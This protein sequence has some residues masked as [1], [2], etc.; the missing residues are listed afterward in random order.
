[1]LDTLRMYGRF[2]FGLRRFLRET[3][4]LEQ[5][6]A[7]IRRRMA[8]RTDAFLRIVERGIF[9]NPSSPYLPLLRAAGCEMGDLRRMVADRGLEDTL[10]ALRGADVYVSFEEFKGRRPMV[11]GGQ[12]YHVGP[13]DF[14]NPFLRTHYETTTGGS[15]G[16][17]V[18]VPQDLD[19]LRVMAQYRLVA[20]EA[21]DILDIPKAIWRGVL[22]AGAGINTVLPPAHFGQVP[23][24]WFT[25][26][27]SRDLRPARR[28]RL[29]T[30][31]IVLISRLNGVKIPWPEPVP[32]DQAIVVARWAKD[33]VRTYGRCLV[34]TPA[35]Q[36]LRV[37]LAAR[38]QGWDLQGVVFTI[39]G[40]PITPAKARGITATGARYFTSYG[41]AES[42][43]VGMGCARPSSC[44]DVHLLKD[45]FAV[46]QHVR[47]V[48]SGIVVPAFN[49][50]SL[51]PT[52]PMILLNMESD[53]FGTLETRSCGCALEALGYT[54]H[55]GDIHS[56]GK[57]TGEGMTLVGSEMIRVL[58][59][60]LPARFGGSSLDYQLSEEEDH[61][62][63]TRLWLIVS[64]RIA[65]ADETGV[66][67]T[68]LDALA[69]S[70]VSADYARAI[71]AQAGTLRVKRAEPVWTARGKFLP[72]HVSRRGRSAAEKRPAGIA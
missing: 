37:C 33:A 21:H 29:A 14:R 63:F 9:E 8:G 31:G 46:I 24:K 58:E 39:T 13:Q 4:T 49:I 64:P 45:G 62:G 34:D 61:Q 38:E 71:W 52:A 53:D 57:L 66:I 1:M 20:R 69:A 5:A 65:V 70:S 43:R 28:F 54:E 11:R 36:A 19:H 10:R 30:N 27:V 3:I 26:V 6:K 55:L 16:V 40:E 50:T 60:V 41:S 72:L 48:E 35:S 17:G 47:E 7:S 42:G 22:P 15:T 56:F 23:H 67:R 2:A 59:E 25:P 44:S 12:V 18:R 51:L 68:V 32:L